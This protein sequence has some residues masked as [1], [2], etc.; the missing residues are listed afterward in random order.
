MKD[1]S[2][3]RRQFCARAVGL[4][5][6]GGGLT[7]VLQACGSVTGPS[8]IASLPRVTGSDAG[9]AVQ[10]P[11]DASSALADV[12]AVALVQSPNAVVLVAHVAQDSFAAFSAICTHETCTITAYAGRNFVCPCHGS[13]FDSSGNA[14][15]GPARVPLHAFQTQFANGVLTIT[16]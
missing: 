2:Q 7:A 3:S 9:D 15:R 6:L 13:E 16:A 8:S 1:A 11:I 5:A 14:I 4:A 12:G 10:V